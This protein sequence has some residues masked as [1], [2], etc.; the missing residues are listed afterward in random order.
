M[1]S[2]ISYLK[3]SDGAFVPLGEV[4]FAPSN[5]RHVEGAIDLKINGVTILDKTLWDDVDQLWAY[6]V[7][8][9]RDLRTNGE[10]DTSFPDQPIDL[11][12]RRTGG[13][14]VLVTLESGTIKQRKVSVD[15]SELTVALCG[16]ADAF[17]ARLSEILPMNRLAYEAAL[18][19]LADT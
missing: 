15:E 18:S 2:V 6:I 17:L 9:I 1:I 11:S 3:D 14:R 4:D 8:A 7:D 13:G 10:S 5:P 12:F 16:A 19:G